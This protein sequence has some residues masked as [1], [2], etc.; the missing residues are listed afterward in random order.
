MINFWCFFKK[1]RI[2]IV[3]SFFD[4]LREFVL[5]IKIFVAGCVLFLKYVYIFV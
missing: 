4:L 2:V 3:V 1:N 5:K